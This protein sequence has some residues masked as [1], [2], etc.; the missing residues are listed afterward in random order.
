MS[1]IFFDKQVSQ[2][3]K[4]MKNLWATKYHITP[5]LNGISCSYQRLIEYDYN[6]EKTDSN[7]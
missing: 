2:N 5:A 3:Q 4:Q 1:N 6:Q 7:R